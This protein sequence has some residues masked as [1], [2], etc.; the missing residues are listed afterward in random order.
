MGGI[1]QPSF[2]S[3]STRAMYFVTPLLWY[4]RL[5]QVH[6]FGKRTFGR[7]RLT[8]Y[9][10]CEIADENSLRRIEFSM[11]MKIARG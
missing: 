6:G 11:S 1:K 4:A 7:K 5:R 3:S 8:S 2:Y 10:W 9:K